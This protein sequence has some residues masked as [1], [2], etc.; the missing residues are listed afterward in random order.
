VTEAAFRRGDLVRFFCA[1]RP[2]LAYF[3]GYAKPDQDGAELC[4]IR[5][6]RTRGFL[7]DTPVEGLELVRRESEC[8]W[9]E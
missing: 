3:E 8:G 2:V 6:L 5:L 1:G 4:S 7:S 9:P